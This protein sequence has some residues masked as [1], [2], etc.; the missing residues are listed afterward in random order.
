M[1]S[2]YLGN[3]TAEIKVYPIPFPAALKL[4]QDNMVKEVQKW[5]FSSGYRLITV[6]SKF[7]GQGNLRL[8]YLACDY[9][10][11]LSDMGG[12]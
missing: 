4:D 12:Q 10:R 3:F 1:C 8:I 5:A 11:P 6:H 9:H 7:R 2:T